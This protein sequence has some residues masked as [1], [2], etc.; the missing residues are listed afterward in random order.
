MT[1]EELKTVENTAYDL[2]IDMILHSLPEESRERVRKEI[3]A[4]KAIREIKFCEECGSRTNGGDT[5]LAC[6]TEDQLTEM[7]VQR[8]MESEQL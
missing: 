1:R 6:A 2:F 8:Y 7:L 5:C 3:Y 4:E